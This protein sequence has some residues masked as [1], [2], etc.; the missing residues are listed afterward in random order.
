MLDADYK[1]GDL[2]T[3]KKVTLMRENGSLAHFLAIFVHF[4][5]SYVIITNAISL[6]FRVI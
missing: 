4:M 2:L 3:R 1:T 5:A 6:S